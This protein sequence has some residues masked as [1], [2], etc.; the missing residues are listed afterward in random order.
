MVAQRMGPLAVLASSSGIAADPLRRRVLGP[1]SRV[2][3]SKGLDYS[4]CS[5]IQCSST[6]RTAMLSGTGM[7]VSI[8]GNKGHTFQ[9]FS[10]SLSTE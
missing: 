6:L 9:Y 2:G 4:P 8:L 10:P 1:H 7:A 5:I 3:H